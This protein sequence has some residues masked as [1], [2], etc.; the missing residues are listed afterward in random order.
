MDTLHL[1]I[2]AMYGDHHVIE[3][4]RILFN[5][6]GIEDVYASSYSQTLQI[7]FQ[8][9]KIDPDTIKQE[10]AHHSYLDTLDIPY[11]SG[12]AAYKNDSNASFFRH[13]VAYQH[14]QNTVGFAQ[15]IDHGGRAIYPCPGFNHVTMEGD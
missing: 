7:D 6:D 9:D 8:P 11:E 3:V 4:R 12:I 5:L 14:L 10:L 13:T 2:P 15:D 1:H